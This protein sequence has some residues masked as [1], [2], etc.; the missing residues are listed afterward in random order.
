MPHGKEWI[1]AL[2]ELLKVGKSAEEV[3]RLRELERIIRQG[4]LEGDAAL[5]AAE[6]E[7]LTSADKAA[8]SIARAQAEY[9][10]AA[11]AAAELADMAGKAQEQARQAGEVVRARPVHVTPVAPAATAPAWSAT[12]QGGERA[13]TSTGD[14]IEVVPVAGG[15]WRWIVDTAPGQP[16][17]GPPLEGTSATLGEA[18]GA[19][20]AASTGRRFTEPGPR[21]PLPGQPLPPPSGPTVSLG[22]SER[23]A[24]AIK[25]QPVIVMELQSL[26]NAARELSVRARETGTLTPELRSAI[27]KVRQEVGKSL[28]RLRANP[29]GFHTAPGKAGAI[30]EVVESMERAAGHAGVSLTLPESTQ[31]YALR[32][33]R[34]T[35]RGPAGDV[36][37][38]YVSRD[39]DTAIRYAESKTGRTFSVGDSILPLDIHGTEADRAAARAAL[40]V[41][42]LPGVTYPPSAP[43][44]VAPRAAWR[45]SYEPNSQGADVAGHFLYIRPMTGEPGRWYWEAV[46]QGGG[47]TVALGEAASA[48]AAKAAAENAVRSV[49][50]APRAAAP[51]PVEALRQE[52]RAKAMVPAQV[53]SIAVPP[54]EVGQ[55]AQV[56][57]GSELMAEGRV[58]YVTRDGWVGVREA[59]LQLHE[60]PMGSV[61]PV[62][63]PSG[64]AIEASGARQVTPAPKRPRSGPP[65]PPQTAT[66]WTPMVGGTQTAPFGHWTLRVRRVSPQSYSWDVLVKGMEP[67]SASGGFKAT[68]EEARAAAE[69]SA[70]KMAPGAPAPKRPRSGHPGA[71]PPMGGGIMAPSPYPL[72][73]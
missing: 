34:I 32:P 13:L 45:P 3:A 56:R 60:W 4:Q 55:L 46:P 66:P 65:A 12:A 62:R 20:E 52:A 41:E 26:D 68:A 2:K 19:A 31:V 38:Y 40:G 7:A 37:V 18:K 28:E 63:G 71:I 64:A 51:N 67:A 25:S 50:V 14:V 47:A 9:D 49:G 15:R 54:P 10:R 1:E 6:R 27:T 17:I 33:W 70:R 73:K 59:N 53:Q 8:A 16:R 69:E 11:Q 48:E 44:V 43:A 36:Q 58:E 23:F 5:R 61:L 39:A 24:A 21:S 30:P 29:K 57:Y 42:R 72:T 22:L 35:L